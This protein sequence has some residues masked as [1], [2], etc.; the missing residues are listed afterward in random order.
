M[1]AMIRFSK[2]II[3]PLV[4][5]LT[6]Y[7]C[8]RNYKLEQ[9][10]RI[11]ESK[12]QSILDNNGTV[13]TVYLTKPYQEPEPYRFTQDPELVK[14]FETTIPTSQIF[15]TPY[16]VN[17]CSSAFDYY[18]K[19]AI[20]SLSFGSQNPI[21]IV[22]INPIGWLGSQLLPDTSF[23]QL[24]DIRIKSSFFMCEDRL[25]IDEPYNGRMIQKTF[26]LDLYSREYLYTQ[27]KLT[28]KKLPLHNRIKPSL[29]FS[30]RPVYNLMDLNCGLYFE[31]SKFNYKLDF[32]VFYYP[33]FNNKPGS[34]IRFSIIYKI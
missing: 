11:Q 18:G 5:L 17:H 24:K 3:S 10:L 9:E 30:Y 25:T 29:E 21:G 2:F 1:K 4:I 16:Q 34:D 7:L 33:R 27:G 31:T 26:N 20:D 13:D 12:Y 19:E 6:I 23:A 8:F 15:N 14:V 22:H 32:N 28:Y